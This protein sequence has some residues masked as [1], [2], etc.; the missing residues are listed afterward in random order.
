MNNANKN[1]LIYYIIRT[2]ISSNEMTS[3]SLNP[4][5][6]RDRERAAEKVR[7]SSAGLK[8]SSERVE[9]EGARD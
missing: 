6:N 7:D 1:I 2:A 3:I 4:R 8:R 5:V 9:N